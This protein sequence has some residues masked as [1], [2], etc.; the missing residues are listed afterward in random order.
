MALPTNAKSQRQ[1][2]DDRKATL[3]QIIACYM[4][5]C[6]NKKTKSAKGT[7]ST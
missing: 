4:I 6:N 1:V 5:V 3:A 2:S 7:G